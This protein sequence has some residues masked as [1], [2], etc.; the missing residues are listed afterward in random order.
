[1]QTV[2]FFPHLTTSSHCGYSHFNCCVHFKF[3]TTQF[4]R[5]QQ[6][7]DASINLVY[8]VVCVAVFFSLIFNERVGS[9]QI[10]IYHEKK[11]RRKKTN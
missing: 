9:S 1:M 3:S 4:L 7:Y 5:Q 2:Q 11:K 8:M 6:S 10:F